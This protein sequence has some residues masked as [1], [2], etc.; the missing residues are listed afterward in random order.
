[1]G[2]NVLSRRARRHAPV[3]RR[4]W[5]WLRVSSPRGRAFE[6]ERF[7]CRQVPCSSPHRCTVRFELPMRWASSAWFM[8]SARRASPSRTMIG[9]GGW[10]EAPLTTRLRCDPPR[11]RSARR[12]RWR[13][14]R[15]RAT[16]QESRRGS[17]WRHVSHDWRHRGREKRHTLHGRSRWRLE[18]GLREHIRRQASSA[19][20]QVAPQRRCCREG[21]RCAWHKKRRTQRGWRH[22]GHRWRSRCVH[23][24]HPSHGRRR[25]AF[26]RRHPRHHWRYPSRQQRQPLRVWCRSCDRWRRRLHGW[27]R[28]WDRR[29]QMNLT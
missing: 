17:S 19:R 13:H 3:R 24:R 4:Q 5:P 15:R 29:R 6:S 11:R 12:R 23:R 7:L 1:M 8:R 22:R 20:R 10:S 21:L 25:C 18:W 28:G 26:L 16:S 2:A 27:R 14:G 9:T